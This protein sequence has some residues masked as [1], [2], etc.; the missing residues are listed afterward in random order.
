[1]LGKKSPLYDKEQKRPDL[2]SSYSSPNL[3]NAVKTLMALITNSHLLQRY[4]LTDLE[5]SMLTNKEM[6]K[7]VL[8]SGVH[9]KLFGEFLGSICRNDTHKS[10][11]ICK[12][13]LRQI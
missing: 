5:K 12:I 3:G 1:M 9:P 13:F 4:P 2:G 11:K 7:I 10:R 8:T 6:I